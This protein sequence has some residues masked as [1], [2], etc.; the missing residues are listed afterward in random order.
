MSSDAGPM[1]EPET[2]VDELAIGCQACEQALRTGGPSDR[3]VLL[4]DTLR[5]PLIGCADTE[6]ELLQHRPAGGLGCPS[7]QL[8]MTR[9]VHPIVPVGNGAVSVLGCQKHQTAAID[10]YQDG[11][12]MAEHLSASLP[13]A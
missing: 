10:R 6:P 1:W 13:S 2:A 12:A 8:A 9:P 7:C 5:V 3:S 4:L 11:L